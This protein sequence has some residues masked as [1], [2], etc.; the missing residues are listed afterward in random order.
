[1]ETMKNM[2]TVENSCE[3]HGKCTFKKLCG[4]KDTLEKH[5]NIL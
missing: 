3:K 5:G 4:M 2:K 1:M